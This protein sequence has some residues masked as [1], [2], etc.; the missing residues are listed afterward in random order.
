MILLKVIDISMFYTQIGYF[1]KLRKCIFFRIITIFSTSAS[2]IVEISNRLFQKAQ[3]CG[4][5]V[6]YLCHL[7]TRSNVL[8]YSFTFLSVTFLFA[9]ENPLGVGNISRFGWT[10]FIYFRYSKEFFNTV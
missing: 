6:L 2:F 9:C 7:T 4:H 10:I 5:F 3:F 8:F 1:F